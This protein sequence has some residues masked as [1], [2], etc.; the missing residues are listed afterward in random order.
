MAVKTFTLY[1][2]LIMETVK[3]ETH[4]SARITKA[5]NPNASEL[6]FHEEAGDESYHERKLE[7]DLF[8]AIDKLKS[9]LS[10]YVAGSS[11]SS[12]ISDDT[13]EIKLDLGDRINTG[14]LTPLADLFSKYIED[15]MLMEWWTPINADRMKI[16]MEHSL[17]DLQNIRNCFAKSAPSS[18]SKGYGDITAS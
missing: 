14:F 12:T 7:R 8:G 16:Y 18:S 17:L 1:K 4:I 13:I 9:E 3:N 5:A 6:A 15:T 2:S 10:N 11:V